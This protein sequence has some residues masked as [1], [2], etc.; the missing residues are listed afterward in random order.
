MTLADEQPPCSDEDFIAAVF[1]F[2]HHKVNTF[3][4]E[5]YNVNL[6]P[7]DKFWELCHH[8]H[9]IKTNMVIAILKYGYDPEITEESALS[10]RDSG[11]IRILLLIRVLVYSMDD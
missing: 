2:D 1:A 9:P 4:A 11:N 6:F 8:E 3:L 10:L 5:G 7:R